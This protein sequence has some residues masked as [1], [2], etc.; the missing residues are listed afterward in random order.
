[1]TLNSCLLRVSRIS[2]HLVTQRRQDESN[3]GL[4]VLYM[5]LY[6]LG[7]KC[8]T[9]IQFTAHAWTHTRIYTHMCACV[10]SWSVS[11]TK[12]LQKRNSHGNCASAPKW[13]S[14]EIALFVFG[15]CCGQKH[16]AGPAP[17]L[18]PPPLHCSLC[19]W[20]QVLPSLKTGSGYLR[21]DTLLSH[22]RISN[23]LSKSQQFF[24]TIS[25]CWC[26]CSCYC[27]CCCCILI[28]W[29]GVPPGPLILH[30]LCT[31]ATKRDF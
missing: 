14:Q 3:R 25:D 28:A 5:R 1:M 23:T 17:P 22:M 24:C 4:N 19:A 21:C 26:S 9:T 12:L 27:C 15:C 13:V 18:P 29:L 30:K 10:W 20:G 6:C 2:T 31:G 11:D 16:C 7:N 8:P